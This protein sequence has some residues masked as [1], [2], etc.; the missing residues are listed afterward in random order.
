MM[1]KFNEVYVIIEPHGSMF[2]FFEDETIYTSE[3]DA[4]KKAVELN[5]EFNAKL[6]RKKGSPISE[7]I[8]YKVMDL[9]T[10]ME[11]WSDDIIDYYTEKDES[12]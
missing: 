11:T 9:K 5:K 10:A 12:Y 2:S 3:I 7:I 6:K 8:I 4:A 1:K